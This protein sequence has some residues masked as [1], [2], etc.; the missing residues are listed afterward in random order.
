LQGFLRAVDCGIQTLTLNLKHR[1]ATTTVEIGLS[2]ASRDAE[3]LFMLIR[4]R[5]ER[6]TLTSPV[7]ELILQAEQLLPAHVRQDELFA[8]AAQSTEQFEQVLDKLKARLG[9][10]AIQGW[11]LIADHRPEAAWTCAAPRA[12]SIDK[13]PA[14]P[15]PLW[16]L[17]QPQPIATPQHLTAGPERIESGW[18]DGADIARD[19]YFV[20][21]AQGAGFWIYRDRNDQHWYLH[22]ICG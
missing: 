3:Q 10:E 6:L 14:T 19:Y 13:P 16:L 1:Q 15:R 22:G 8:T 9:S 21:D 20:R 2:T 17:V 5:F 11:T 12:A 18:W 7:L 4:E